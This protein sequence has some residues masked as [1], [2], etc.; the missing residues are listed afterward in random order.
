MKILKQLREQL[1]LSQQ[2]M[3]NL[4]GTT[5]SRLSHAEA[6]RRMLEAKAAE[7][8][9]QLLQHSNAPA[10]DTMEQAYSNEDMKTIRHK[11]STW[12]QELQA[13]QQLQQQTQQTRRQNQLLLQC[14]S[15][16]DAQANELPVKKQRWLKELHYKAT[17]HGKKK[18]DRNGLWLAFQ[19]KVLEY[20]VALCDEMLIRGKL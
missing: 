15:S 3:A 2:E 1:G 10:G 18:T 19:I 12:L 20:Q 8:L 9:A 6:G 13:A 14:I 11:R 4:L 5:R 7:V 16:L 17:Q